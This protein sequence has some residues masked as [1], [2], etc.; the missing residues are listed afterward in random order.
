MPIFQYKVRDRNG[1]AVEG[2][3][4]APTLLAAGE[5]LHGLGYLPISIDEVKNSS[6]PLVSALTERF[7][8]VGL[9]DLVL[10]SQQLSTLYKAGLPLLTGL[11]SLKEQTENKKLRAVLDQ[12]C[13]DVESGNPLFASM[14]KHP[15]VFSEIY[16]NMIRAGET[17]GRLGESLDRFVILANRE[18]DTRR[19]LKEATRYPKIVIL[20]VLIAFAILIAFVIPRF[21]ATFA[22]F[23]MPLPLPTRIMIR[24]NDLFQS[25]WYLILGVLLG[26][27]LVLKRALGTERGRY[28][29]DKIKLRI[30]ILGP[31]FLKIGLSRFTNTFGMLNRTGIPILQALEITATTVDNV[32]LSQSIHRIQQSVTEGS[33]LTEALKETKQFTPLV[34]QM[35][36][37][38]ESSGTLDEMLGRVTDYYDL[39]VDHAL[40]KLPTYIEPLLTLVLG[41]VVLF[42]AL[43]VFL[44]WWN[45]ASLFRG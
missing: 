11:A 30:P 12:V 10:F 34:I 15:G 35:V 25:F 1:K 22:Q 20:A 6:P 14:A 9:E 18:L 41:G 37:V 27:L 33:S 31:I 17:S 3:L 19:R 5:Q 39:E 2:R 28:L 44:P 21:A 36:N 16:V 4:E 43:A 7:K 29:W 24:V 40:K 42:L 38:G 45:M 23:N 13:K 32:I 26:G 8:K